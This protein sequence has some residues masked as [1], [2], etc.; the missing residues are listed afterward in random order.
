MRHLCFLCLLLLPSAA[1]ADVVGPEPES[2]PPGSRPSVAH[3]GPYCAP[4]AECGGDTECGAGET[5]DVI[6]QCVETRGCGGLM[7]PDS[8]PCTL[9][10]VVGPCGGDGSCAVGE[11]RSRSVCS[12]E[13]ASDGGCGCRAAGSAPG[14]HA[15][16]GLLALGLLAFRRSRH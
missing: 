14:S 2:C 16:L 8:E 1:L 11:C 15:A 4:V 12:G 3:S 13:V 5:C 9:E 7:A 6:Q 10:H